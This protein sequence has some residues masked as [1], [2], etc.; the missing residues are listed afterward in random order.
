MVSHI[1]YN[2][3][4]NEDLVIFFF[5]FKFITSFIDF[6]VHAFKFTLGMKS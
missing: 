6:H 4:A 1:H 3:N 5:T 2:I